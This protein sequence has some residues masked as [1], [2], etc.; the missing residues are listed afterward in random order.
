MNILET[1]TGSNHRLIQP[2]TVGK[3]DGA[4]TI[5]LISSAKKNKGEFSA[6]SQIFYPVSL[7]NVLSP[8][9]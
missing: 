5:Y 2:H 6:H 9:H 4:P 1:V 3:K 7:G 8:I